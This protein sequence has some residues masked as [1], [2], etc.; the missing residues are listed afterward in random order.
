MPQTMLLVG[1]RKGCFILESDADRR[2]GRSRPVLRGLADLPR[3]ARSGLRRHLRGRGERVARRRRVAQRR[4]RR[5]LG[6]LERG[7]RATARRR[8]QAVQGLGSDGRA[9]APARG[10]RGLRRLR[11]PR[12]RRDLV[13]PEHARRPARPGAWNDPGQPAARPS[14]HARDPGAPGRGGPLLGR[15]AGVRHLRD[16]RRRRAPG[17]RATAGC[18][19]TGRSRTPRSATACTS[20]SCRRSTT[21]GSTSRTTS[22]CTAATTPGNPGSRSPTGCRPSSAS[23]PP[24]T[25]TTA[26]AST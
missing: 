12:R 19:P 17:R 9:R 4:P 6:A 25:R 10:R 1:T 8:A 16:D 22:A 20:S 23:P 7:S 3:G 26:T 24:P 18:A 5:D 15:G 14:R 21:T 13:A 11:E 2:T